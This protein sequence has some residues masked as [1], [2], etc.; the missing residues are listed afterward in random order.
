MLRNDYKNLIPDRKDPGID[1]D[2]KSIRQFRVG[3]PS[4]RRPSSVFAIWDHSPF[5]ILI[6]D[7]VRGVI[8]WLPPQCECHIRSITSSRKGISI[9]S[10]LLPISWIHLT[11][12]YAIASYMKTTEI[13]R[14]TTQSLAKTT[15]ICGQI[16]LDF[17]SILSTRKYL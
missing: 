5:F 11:S 15:T 3:S 13:H 9:Y 16:E 14:C 12:D 7:H 17:M 10:Q 8:L 1:V 4:N 6:T 2:K